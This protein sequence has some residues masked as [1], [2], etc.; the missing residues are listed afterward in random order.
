[1]DV[2]ETRNLG[3]TSPG[4]KEL[5]ESNASEYHLKGLHQDTYLKMMF[6]IVLPFFFSFTN[7]K[8]KGGKKPSGKNQLLNLKRRK[9]VDMMLILLYYLTLYRRLAGR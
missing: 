9:S 4:H 8:E 7:H 1:M 2:I 6:L 5:W 3:Q